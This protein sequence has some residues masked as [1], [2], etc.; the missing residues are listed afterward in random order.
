[1]GECNLYV[2]II[3]IFQYMSFIFK[4]W[5]WKFEQPSVNLAE[6][7]WLGFENFLLELSSWH[8]GQWTVIWE[9]LL[10]LQYKFRDDTDALD[11]VP[12]LNRGLFPSVPKDMVFF[13]S[14]GKWN[15]LIFHFHSYSVIFSFAIN[16][17]DLMILFSSYILIHIFPIHQSTFQQLSSCALD[18]TR[19]QF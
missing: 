13:Y 17:Y 4:V 9:D 14:E 2:Y 19:A 5:F 15:K 12:T 8:P 11:L 10:P 1:M 3:Y 16:W 6:K 18:A 7:H